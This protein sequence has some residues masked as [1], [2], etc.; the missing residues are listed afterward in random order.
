MYETRNQLQE[1]NCKEHKHVETKQHATKQLIGQWRNQRGNK[2]Y[3]ET[4]EKGNTTIQNLWDAAKAVLEGKF[5][6][7]EVYWSIFLFLKKQEKSQINNQNVHLKV[8]VKE[9]QVKTKIIRKEIIK[10]RVEIN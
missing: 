8:L 3:L 7:I 4:N 5:K 1:E 9:K 2:R 10:M 6:P